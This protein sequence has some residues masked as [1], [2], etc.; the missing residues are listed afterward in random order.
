[1]LN[2][3]KQIKTN[4]DTLYNSILLL[5]RN[6]LLYTDFKLAD[7]FQNR[8]NLI[9]LHTSFLFSV[10]KG[11]KQFTKY[12]EF[13]QNI[14]DLIF[15]KIELNMREIGYGDVSVNKHMKFLVKTFYNIL[16]ECE[17]YKDN[18][19]KAK[20]DFLLKYLKLL[21]EGNPNNIGKLIRYF[22]KYE[23]FCF[24]LNPNSVLKGSLNFIYN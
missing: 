19:Q 12:G 18:S 13:Y 6:K 5:T 2:N 14:F 4:K 17:K 20:K 11:K 15:R 3:K 7:T 21:T 23:A 24:D 1:M 16:L 8:I 10:V 9:F 22:D